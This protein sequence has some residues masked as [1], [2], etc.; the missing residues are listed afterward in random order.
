MGRPKVAATD[1]QCSAM[2]LPCDCHAPAMRLIGL[3]QSVQPG[4]PRPPPPQASHPLGLTP[5][6][7][8]PPRPHTPQASTPLGLTP[9]TRLGLT[10]P[11]QA[12]HPL[13]LTLDLH[14]IN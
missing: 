6:G 2:R 9:P 10:P 3:V 7:L 11:R 1:Q 13:G 8:T 14:S 12:S 4:S 5:P